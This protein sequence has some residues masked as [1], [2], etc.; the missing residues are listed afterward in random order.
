MTL[1]TDLE[2]LA[3]DAGKQVG[4]GEVVTEQAVDGLEAGLGQARSTFGPGGRATSPRRLPVSGTSSD[5]IG[6]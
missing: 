5:S 4:V 6:R 3:L 2:E 1:R